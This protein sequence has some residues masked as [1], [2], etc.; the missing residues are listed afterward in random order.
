MYDVDSENDGVRFGEVAAAAARTTTTTT[1]SVAG[2]MKK[3]HHRPSPTTVTYSVLSLNRTKQNDIETV[4]P[5]TVV[6]TPIFGV[7]IANGRAHTIYISIYCFIFY[8]DFF[9]FV[10]G[11]CCFFCVFFWLLVYQKPKTVKMGVRFWPYSV[12]SFLDV[13]IHFVY[14]EVNVKKRICS[15]VVCLCMRYE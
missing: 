8:D 1:A 14:I 5:L 15:R 10:F 6:Y 9:C 2:A 7:Y 12:A 3:A 13:C 11:F 4:S